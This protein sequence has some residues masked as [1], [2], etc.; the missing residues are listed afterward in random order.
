MCLFIYVCMVVFLD[1]EGDLWSTRDKSPPWMHCL[2]ISLS[3]SELRWLFEL[4]IHHAMATGSRTSLTYSKGHSM[5]LQGLS[6]LR[7]W[8]KCEFS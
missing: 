8:S 6:A 3:V 2:M 7:N 5:W 1:Q 4:S